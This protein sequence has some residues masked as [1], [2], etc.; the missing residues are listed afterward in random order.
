ME[1]LKRYCRNNS[2]YAG[3]NSLASITNKVLDR[4]EVT[5]LLF[6]IS[7]HFEVPSVGKS[8]EK[9]GMI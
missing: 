1:V 7:V 9:L 5:T 4:E 8:K 3:R 6:I 2:S